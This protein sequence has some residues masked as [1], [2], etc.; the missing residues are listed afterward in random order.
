[1]IV[2]SDMNDIGIVR[3]CKAFPDLLT[4]SV[5][6]FALG[7]FGTQS[8]AEERRKVEGSDSKWYSIV[9]H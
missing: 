2:G 6:L 5:R 4:V 8:E 3:F 9:F 1:M 7:H